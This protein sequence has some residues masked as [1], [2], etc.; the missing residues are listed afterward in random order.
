MPALGCGR[1]RGVTFT[2][3]ERA[4]WP[5]LAIVDLTT[6]PATTT[7][8][9]RGRQV[10]Y[11]AWSPDGSRLAVQTQ[12][13]T[14]GAPECDV[15]VWVMPSAGGDLVPLSG[16]DAH[17]WGTEWSPDGEWILQV[18]RPDGR[19]HVYLASADGTVVRRL[20]D[21]PGSDFMPVFSPDGE[22]IA[23]GSGPVVPDSS[24][25]EPDVSGYQV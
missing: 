2:D 6:D 23:F 1:C 22:W 11:A 3:A 4:G 8:P 16:P 20:T 14:D 9:V 13:C 10:F 17:A 24:T 15:A 19:D 25:D 12:T 21:T 5:Y 7:V 18:R